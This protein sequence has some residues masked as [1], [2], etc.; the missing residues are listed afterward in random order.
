MLDR[1]R[2]EDK[3][4]CQLRKHLELGHYKE[5]Y[6][7]LDRIGY[8]YN[9]HTQFLT[10]F[11]KVKGL[12][13]Y[14]YLLYALTRKETSEIY[15]TLC[16]EL[17]YMSPFFDDYYF[18]I[19]KLYRKAFELFP[20]DVTLKEAIDFSDTD[21]YQKF[22][23]NLPYYNFLKTHNVPCE[24]LLYAEEPQND[25]AEKE[26]E[27]LGM[28]I[29]EDGME[30]LILCWILCGF[31]DYLNGNGLCETKEDCQKIIEKNDKMISPVY[32]SERDFAWE[33]YYVYRIMC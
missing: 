12:H 33:V 14:C 2:K 22:E 31:T 6:D 15:L 13:R 8:R 30:S 4:F 25:F 9:E 23:N 11:S 7:Q 19:Q 16:D 20:E 18:M 3:L 28:D 21:V 26:L 32:S 17:M 27:Y 24:I 10:D 5:V 1:K 29:V